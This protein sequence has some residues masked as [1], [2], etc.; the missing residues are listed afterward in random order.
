MTHMSS[1]QAAFENMGSTQAPC[2][3]PGRAEIDILSSS[4]VRLS[5]SDKFIKRNSLMFIQK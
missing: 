2:G 1:M 5:S 3:Q 4:I